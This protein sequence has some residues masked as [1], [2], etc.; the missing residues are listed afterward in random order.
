MGALARSDGV[1]AAAAADAADRALDLKSAEIS[2]KLSKILL[3][4]SP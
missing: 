1:D 2:L 3:F 4:S